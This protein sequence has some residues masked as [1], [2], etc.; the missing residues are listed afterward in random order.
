MT[1]P[2]PGPRM[3]GSMVTRPVYRLVK[4]VAVAAVTPTPLSIS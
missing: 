4:D 1:P 3:P 2:G